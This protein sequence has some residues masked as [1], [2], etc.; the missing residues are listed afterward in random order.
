MDALRE[1][2]KLWRHNTS[3]HGNFVSTVHDFTGL[4]F[5]IEVK[6]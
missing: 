1:V 6:M 2:L 4:K 3:D 5:E